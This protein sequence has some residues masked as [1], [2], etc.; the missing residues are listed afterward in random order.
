MTIA[1]CPVSLPAMANWLEASASVSRPVSGDLATT[2]NFALV[3]SGVPTSEENTNASGAV[4]GQRVDPR[5]GEPVQQ[6]G[7]EADAA[8]VG[9]QHLVVELE[10]GARGVA[11]ADVDDQRPSE[12]ATRSHASTVCLIRRRPPT[13]RRR[14]PPRRAGFGASRVIWSPLT[15]ATMCRSSVSPTACA[16]APS[17]AARTGLGRCP[18]PLAS[19][20]NRSTTTSGGSRSRAAA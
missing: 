17:V 8:E 16:A 13:G 7:T 19:A 2:A 18:P 10:R 3:V 15:A 4:R 6:P 9:T 5:R 11:V 14:C 12:E 20:P 1:S